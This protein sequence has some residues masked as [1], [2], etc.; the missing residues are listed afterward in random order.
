M[1]CHSAM[2]CLSFFKVFA[3]LR[4]RLGRLM[5]VY[6][7]V[8]LCVCVCLPTSITAVCSPSERVSESV[9]V[10]ERERQVQG[11]YNKSLFPLKSIRNLLNTRELERLTL[12]SITVKPGEK[13]FQLS[14]P[15]SDLCTLSVLST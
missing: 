9:C 13:S 12:L 8:N 4:D 1:Q 10:Y 11:T 3:L 14:F 15:I 6:V 2:F 7:E 5:A